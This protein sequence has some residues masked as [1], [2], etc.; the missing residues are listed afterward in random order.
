MSTPK[1]IDVTPFEP[2]IIKVHYDGFDWKKLQPICEKLVNESP[3]PTSL[4]V[5]DAKSSVSN[6]IMPHT[7]PEFNDFYKWLESNHL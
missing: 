7:M 6:P 5:N 4:E 3:L 2:M 1:L